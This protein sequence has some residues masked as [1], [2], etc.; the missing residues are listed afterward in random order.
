MQKKLSY[1]DKNTKSFPLVVAPWL[2]SL[3]YKTFLKFHSFFLSK[4][5]NNYRHFI[6][7][8]LI[9]IAYIIFVVGA[10]LWPRSYVSSCFL[11][12]KATSLIIIFKIHHHLLHISV[13]ISCSLTLINYPINCF[14]S[15]L[16][17]EAIYSG[18][19]NVECALINS[20]EVDLKVSASFKPNCMRIT[21]NC[22][23][24][25]QCLSCLFWIHILLS[26]WLQ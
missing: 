9:G 6:C 19:N 15:W 20:I 8:L 26:F 23:K 17:D 10:K 4:P 16:A 25:W 13:I 24:F 21:F 12:V 14:H 22:K 3:S 18:I 5:F 1:A 7:L 11:V 2:S